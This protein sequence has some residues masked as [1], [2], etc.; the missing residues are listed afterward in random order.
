MGNGKAYIFN[1]GGVKGIRREDWSIGCRKEESESIGLAEE[2]K[3][4]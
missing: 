1:K 3:G 2:K 4:G